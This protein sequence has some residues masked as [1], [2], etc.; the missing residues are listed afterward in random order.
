MCVCV[1]PCVRP[2]ALPS[3]GPFIRTYIHILIIWQRASSWFYRMTKIFK[4]KITHFNPTFNSVLLNNHAFSASL[5]FT[6]DNAVII[7]HVCNIKPLGYSLWETSDVMEQNGNFLNTCSHY[8][9][10][11]S[12]YK[13]HSCFELFWKILIHGHRFFFDSIFTATIFHLFN[14]VQFRYHDWNQHFK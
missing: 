6:R 3:V 12:N 11:S 7:L 1:C 10:F 9:L 5:C 2:P 14:C 4:Q 8:K 13:A